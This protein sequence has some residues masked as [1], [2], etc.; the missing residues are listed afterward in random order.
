M[1]KSNWL[2]HFAY[3]RESYSSISTTAHCKEQS[4]ICKQSSKSK[5]Q[6]DYNTLHEHKIFYFITPIISFPFF[7][8]N[9][10]LI[11][12][13]SE[14]INKSTKGTQTMHNIDTYIKE[15]QK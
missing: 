12:T 9:G 5:C 10:K 1:S 7:F 4:P 11:M 15:N 3:A 14:Y 2:A 8:F 6:T 13:S